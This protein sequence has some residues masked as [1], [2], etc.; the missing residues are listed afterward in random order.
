MRV[1]TSLLL[2]T[3][4]ASSLLAAPGDW[5]PARY[6]SGSAPLI[7][8][9]APGGGE[10]WAELDVTPSGAVSAVSILRDTPPF[11]AMVEKT[12]T[13]W[14]FKP[15][16]QLEPKTPN[17]P[18]SR[19][20]TVRSRVLVAAMFRPPTINTPT[21][22]TVP[23]P[24]RA[25]S[26]DVPF[27]VAFPLP[28]FPPNKLFDG[29]ALVEVKVSPDGSVT[30]AAIIQSAAGFDPEALAAARQWRFQAARVENDAVPAY[31]YIAFAFR[32]PITVAGKGER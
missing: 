29:V 4:A 22:G 21:F 19:M 23:K 5:V 13:T 14:R 20:R 30:D 6:R 24:L 10:V 28:Q 26:S 17:G 2:C 32:Q 12:L 1:A 25:A 31:A 3:L 18:P 11:T 15:A 16:E 7:Q 9:Q 8:I 27:P